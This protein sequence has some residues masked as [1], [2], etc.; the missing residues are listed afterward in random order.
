VT[1]D[2]SGGFRIRH[3]PWAWGEILAGSKNCGEPRVHVLFTH[4]TLPTFHFRCCCCCLTMTSAS[5]Y[6]TRLLPHR[7]HL[8]ST[9]PMLPIPLAYPSFVL[10]EYSSSKNI[11]GTKHN[12]YYHT[13]PPLHRP[14]YKPERN[15]K[16]RISLEQLRMAARTQGRRL[17]ICHEQQEKVMNS[18]EAAKY[19]VSMCVVRRAYT[20]H[21]NNISQL[22]Y[23]NLSIIESRHLQICQGGELIFSASLQLIYHW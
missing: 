1:A 13:S 14:G 23:L 3:S 5:S 16:I 17:P 11:I 18:L 6:L 12:R 7:R 2:G 22:R 21:M 20:H 8:F 10:Q 4:L 15:P 19:E 9:D